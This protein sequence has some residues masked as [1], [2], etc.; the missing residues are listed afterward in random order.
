[1]STTVLFCIQCS[2]FPTLIHWC[3]G[4]SSPPVVLGM[5]LE[6]ISCI[7]LSTSL[8]L[9]HHIILPTNPKK[10]SVHLLLPF[11]KQL[12]RKLPAKH[13]QKKQQISLSLGVL[14]SGRPVLAQATLGYQKIAFWPS[15]GWAAS[16][17]VWLVNI[18]HANTSLDGKLS[19]ASFSI[20]QVINLCILNYF[21]F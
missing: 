12:P 21:F 8:T 19:L 1:M 2:A 18:Q 13:D 11:Y 5:R 7:S 4:L 17:Q 20:R 14:F 9:W 3:S 6:G 15:C 10:T 16:S